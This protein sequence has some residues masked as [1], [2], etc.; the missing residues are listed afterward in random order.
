[1]FKQ[2]EIPINNDLVLIGGGHSHIMLMMELSK[3]PIEGNRITLISNEIDT[4]YSGMIPGFIEGIYTWRET[5]IDLYKLCFKLNIRFI[6][7]E[8][9]EISAI[10]KEIVL[11]NRPKIKFDVLSINTGIQSSNKTIKGALKYCV[12][13]K[14]ISKLS[15][16]FLTEIKNNNN[17]AF[18]GGGPASVELALGLQKRL[19]NSKSNLK[20]SIITGK[21]GLL[22]SF[23]NKTRKVAKETLQNSQI[24]V[25]EKEEVIEVQK[26]TLILSNKTKLKIDKSIL[27][28]NAMAPV[29]IKKSDIILNPDNFIIVN[30]KF[31]T[32]YN[33]VFAAGDI[34]DF[35]NQNLSKSGV[36][37]VKSGKPLAKSIRR[38]IQKKI[39]IP[40]KFNKNYLSIIGL[41]NGLAI[42]T[43]YN[44][45]FT[46]RFSFLLKK[47][48]DQKFVKKFNN[49][50]QDNY[51]TFRSLYKV[52]DVMI[53]KNNKNIPSY[54]MQCR[55]CAAKVDFNALKATLPK[56][57]IITSEDAININNYPKLYQSVDMISSIVSDPY[58]LGKIA[59][60]HAI[61]DIIAVNS[62]LI[63]ALMILQLP[64]SNS[65]INSRDLEQVTSGAREVFKSANCS[66]SGGHTMIG[67][68]KDPVIGFSVI[69]EKKSV[70]NNQ[71][72][73]KLKINDILILTEKIGSG[74][75]FAGINNDI[76]DSFYQIEVLDQMSQGNINFSKI[77]D[78]LKIL[79]MTDIT[80][81]G[82]ANH[83]LNLVKRDVGKTGLTIFPDKIPIFK[84]VTKALSKNVRS[85]LYDKNFNTAQ[86][87]LVYDRETKLID[88]ILFDPQTVG[89]IAFL[90][91][92]EEKV[93]QFKI[94]KENKINFTEIGFVNNLDNKIRIT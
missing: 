93:K 35:N 45:T 70:N 69:G 24:N 37:A 79:S 77:S 6:H 81:F 64:F 87:E 42:A 1:M 92:Q 59:A 57:I 26:D 55:G 75:I 39:P 84:G 31:Q 17:I 63:S 19:K 3:N 23:P 14:P 13:V 88:E 53:Q 41:S 32:N 51:Y 22:S 43:K 18:I 46:S 61:S 27:S 15:N 40:Y 68:D 29:W 65:E 56:E 30:D 76:I 38:F 71:T 58:L 47:L 12:P 34:V 11:K 7:S 25:I 21:N 9:T 36:Y 66:I 89:G 44:F 16:N 28:T 86:K 83:L 94:L 80:G 67:K 72:R 49:L 48:I 10:N 8:V 85:S 78:K 33:Y 91:P 82:L 54:Q 52:F 2:Q 50:N 4:P 90:I 74:I 62:K 60:N 20:I 5:H 73:S